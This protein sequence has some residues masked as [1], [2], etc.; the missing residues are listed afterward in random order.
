MPRV[1]PG[2]RRSLLFQSVPRHDIFIMSGP[3]RRV[4]KQPF[5][6]ME[7]C[8][9]ERREENW[10]GWVQ[11][12]ETS[13]EQLQR[14]CLW[15]SGSFCCGKTIWQCSAALTQHWKENQLPSWQLMGSEGRPGKAE[16]GYHWPKLHSLLPCLIS[17]T[18]LRLN[19][20]GFKC[21]LQSFHAE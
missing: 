20:A 4:W 12:V 15:D 6:F 8:R 21:G 11:E 17:L 1:F 9:I 18:V 14:A 16:P 13:L 5:L 7:S 3:C 2:D 19:C 10:G